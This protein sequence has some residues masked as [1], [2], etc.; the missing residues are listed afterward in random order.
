MLPLRARRD[1]SVGIPGNCIVVGEAQGRTALL[2][3]TAYFPADIAQPVVREGISVR[4]VAIAIKLR[5]D[6]LWT[7][8]GTL[9]PS[10]SRRGSATTRSL[11]E[12]FLG[13]KVWCEDHGQ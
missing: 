7:H 6:W 5:W 8:R 10:L 13:V 3:P 1:L 11:S 12:V 4:D 9:Y 2:S